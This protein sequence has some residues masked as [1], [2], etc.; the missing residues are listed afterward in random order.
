MMAI[1]IQPRLLEERLR[2]NGQ[3]KDFCY[4]IKNDDGFP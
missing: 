2:R 4:W 3:R 1:A